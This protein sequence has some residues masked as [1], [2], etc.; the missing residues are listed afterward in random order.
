MDKVIMF[1]VVFRVMH[2]TGRRWWTG[3][4][5]VISC[6]GWVVV[7]LHAGEQLYSLY[8]EPIVASLYLVYS[9]FINEPVLETQYKYTDESFGFQWAYIICHISIREF[10][11]ETWKNV[12]YVCEC[13]CCALGELAIKLFALLGLWS[14]I[15][16][17]KH[18]PAV[19]NVFKPSSY[20]VTWLLR[21]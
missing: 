8:S 16:S 2:S 1:D 12:Y 17:I 9:S 10:E 19:V 21:K 14:D 3:L 4:P 15:K 5:L 7:V 20:V 6:K 11:Q 18:V 13:V